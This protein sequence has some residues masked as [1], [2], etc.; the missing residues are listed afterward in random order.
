MRLVLPIDVQ[1]LL[2]VVDV[3]DA[4]LN[5][6]LRLTRQDG[7]VDD[8]G[9][10]ENQ[11]VARHVLLLLYLYVGAA[12]L[13]LVTRDKNHVS[14]VHLIGHDLRPFTLAMHP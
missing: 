5:Q 9:A 1:G 14:R 2:N 12:R 4:V 7:L 3:G 8:G 6:R 13:G 10:G 11:Q